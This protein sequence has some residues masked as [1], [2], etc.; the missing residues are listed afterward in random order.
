MEKNTRFTGIFFRGRLGKVRENALKVI[1]DPTYNVRHVIE[2]VLLLQRRY[3][4]F[5]LSLM[6]ERY[7]H[8]IAALIMHH[9]LVKERIHHLDNIERETLESLMSEAANLSFDRGELKMLTL[10]NSLRD[11]TKTPN[12]RLREVIESL[13]RDMPDLISRDTDTHRSR[14]FDLH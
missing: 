4:Q 6:E 1:D 13:P 10:R 12:D 8:E 11:P 9:P 3:R 5:V 14:R 7:G 2:Q